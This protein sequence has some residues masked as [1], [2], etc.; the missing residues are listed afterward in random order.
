MA[1]VGYGDGSGDGLGAILDVQEH[2]LR[3]PDHPIGKCQRT[4]PGHQFRPTDGRRVEAF[5]DAI[6]DGKHMVSAR[7]DHEDRHQ[8][9]QPVRMLCR[10]VPC[11]AEI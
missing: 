4:A 9:C 6:I 11:Q 2:I 8:L 7:L 1:A 3:H 5:D 10:Q